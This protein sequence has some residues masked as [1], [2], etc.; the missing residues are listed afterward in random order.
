MSTALPAVAA[1]ALVAVLVAIVLANV[2]VVP[3]GHAYV[4]ERLGRYLQTLPA[5][6][7]I[8][9]PFVDRV[10]SRHRLTEE[11]LAVPRAEYRTR[12]GAVVAVDATVTFRIVDAE[13]ATYAAADARVALAQL[14]Q[15][16]LRAEVAGIDLSEA[17]ASRA[18][19]D[20]AV[21][22][23]LAETSGALGLAVLGHEITD[24]NRQWKESHA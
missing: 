6:L 1:V 3:Q 5:G 4:V 12:D 22:G 21:A 19:V 9:F 7:H 24:L 20:R 13:R 8:L 2:V 17:N 18:A 11:T 14:A 15:T 16:S 23:R 10:A